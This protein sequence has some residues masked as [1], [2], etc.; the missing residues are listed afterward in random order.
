MAILTRASFRKRV[1]GR[2]RWQTGGEGQSHGFHG[3]CGEHGRRLGVL[4]VTHYTLLVV[5]VDVEGSGGGQ[6][7]AVGWQRGAYAVD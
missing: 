6:L 1:H 3:L 7:V 4:D 2:G 5:A